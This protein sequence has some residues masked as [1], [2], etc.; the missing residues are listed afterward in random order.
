MHFHCLITQ[1]FSFRPSFPY[2]FR[3]FFLPLNISNLIFL[4][5][6]SQSV[7]PVIAPNSTFSE[8]PKQQISTTTTNKIQHTYHLS[9]VLRI[10]VGVIVLTVLLLLI[11]I[12][13]ICKNIKE[14]KGLD[15]GDTLE[16]SQ[17]TQPIKIQMTREGSIM[18][19]F[20]VQL[21]SLKIV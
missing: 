11:L 2:R 5:P 9:L 6:S 20:S 17:N 1:L 21:S 18:E 8:A 4:G 13:L 19:F 16:K 14:L 15:E 12:Q 10:G 3:S 7:I